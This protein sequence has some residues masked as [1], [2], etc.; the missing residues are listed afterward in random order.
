MKDLPLVSIITVVYNGQQYIEDVI[1]SVLNQS[2]TNIEYIIIDGGSTDNTLAIIKKYENQISFW[3]SEDDN[4]ISD[5]FNKGILRSK[6]EIIGIINS[7]DWYEK[8][9][10]EKVVAKLKDADVVYS[11]MQLWKNEEKDFIVK[12]DHQFLTKEMTVNHPSVFVRKECYTQFGL[13]D[14]QYE[15]AMDYDLMLRLKINNRK[16]VYIPEVLANMRWAGLSDKNWLTGCRETL[17]IKNKYIPRKKIN[18]LLYFCKHVLAIAISKT[19]RKT[20]TDFLIKPYRSRFAKVKK[21]YQ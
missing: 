6:G 4:G 3:I 7:D 13:F 15:L 9:A 16:F 14:T 21:I 17:S 2:Y 18:H 11:D 12:G 19:L 10:V 1:R 5:A 20:K 8:D